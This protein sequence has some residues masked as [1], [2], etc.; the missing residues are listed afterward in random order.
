MHFAAPS[1]PARARLPPK[2]VLT[3]NMEVPEAWLV[4]ATKA[5][6]DL[7][8]LRLVG[9][10]GGRGRGAWR[11]VGFRPGEGSEMSTGG[12]PGGMTRP[13]WTGFRL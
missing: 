3:L 12:P 9:W 6:Y 8:N 5:V 11:G 7:D 2:R 13:D 10:R 1:S 4:E